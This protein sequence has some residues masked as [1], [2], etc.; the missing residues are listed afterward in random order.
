MSW[1]PAPTATRSAASDYRRRSPL[2]PAS[3]LAEYGGLPFP[4]PHTEAELTALIG[5]LRYPGSR[6]ETVSVGH[7]R[8]DASGTAA[9]AFTTAWR[10]RGGTVLA[11]VDWPE[12]AATWLR[13]ATRLTRETPDAW[14]VA[15]APASVP[16]ARPRLSRWTARTRSG[17]RHRVPVPGPTRAHTYQKKTPQRSSTFA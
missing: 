2:I 8:D 13:P 11:V 9:E 7:S 10:A 6:I 1:T 3:D 15:A 16:K 4:P 17:A 12:S 5:L 14:V